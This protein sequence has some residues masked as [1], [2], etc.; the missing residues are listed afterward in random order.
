MTPFKEANVLIAGTA[1]NVE[2]TIE[3]E[4]KKLMKAF[5]NFNSIKFLIVESDSSDQ[6][7]NELKKLQN[8][9]E[10][11]QFI[12]LGALKELIPNRVE[13]IAYCRNQ[14]VQE[15]YAEPT[16]SNIDYVAIADL[17][18]VN[19]LLTSE[20]VESCWR[21]EF[22]WDVIT[23]NQLDFYYDIYALRHQYWSPTNCQI[24]QEHLE[25]LMG[26]D[27]SIN[28]AVWAKQVQLRPENRLI[29]VD[30]AFGGFA[31]YKREAFDAGKYSAKI[32]DTLVCEHV[33]FHE[34]LKNAGYRIY[35]HC[36]LINCKRPRGPTAHESNTEYQF[37]LRLIQKCGVRIFGKRRFQKYLK[38]LIEL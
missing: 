15:V 33:P 23:A 4:V 24:Q 9:I 2:N 11:F 30:S 20:K 12:T 25:P 8:K 32:N 38:Q 27:P 17:D 29:E 13:R 21:G 26:H 7:I 35:I 3:G 1:R 34:L 36:G 37:F 6:T 16:Y 5:K 22:N 14:I 31:I 28:L 18:G 10:N 19:D